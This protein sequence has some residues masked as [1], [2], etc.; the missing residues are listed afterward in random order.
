MVEVVQEARFDTANLVPERFA[1]LGRYEKVM[2]TT[3][4]ADVRDDAPMTAYAMWL[5]GEAD[6]ALAF[7]VV[8][9]Q[10]PEIIRR[11]FDIV[12]LSTLGVGTAIAAAAGR[13]E[14]MR[15]WTE[16][17]NSF[18]EPGVVPT[19]EL[20]AHMATAITA[21]QRGD[22]E[23]AAAALDPERTGI[24]FDGWPPRATLMSVPL[25]YLVRPDAR[26]MFDRHRYGPAAT[27]ALEAARALVALRERVD[28]GPAAHLPWS[29][30]DLLRAN[31]LPVHLAELGAAACAAGSAQAGDVVR[32]LP[33]R[34]EILPLAR[35][36]L[37]ERL[38]SSVDQFADHDV[39]TLP[40]AL[41]TNVLGDVELFRDGVRVD[42]ERWV[43]RAKVR[44]LWCYLVCRGG[45]TRD[46]IVRDLWPDSSEDPVAEEK[47]YANLRS[48]LSMLGK[49]IEPDRTAQG[50]AFIHADT[51]RIDLVAFTSDF[52]QIQD[53]SA[54]ALA[55]DASQAPL[56]SLRRHGHVV[57]LYRGALAESLD[58]G[59]IV[60]ERIRLRTLALSSLCRVAELTLARGEPEAA[61]DLARRAL[62][63]DPLHERAGRTFVSALAASGDRGAALAAAED[64][65]RRWTAEDWTLETATTRAFERLRAGS[66]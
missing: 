25:V 23:A 7:L 2:A 58:A 22:E 42:D 20:F 59:W 16:H 32:S 37:A 44:E 11:G 47:A 28:P 34:G 18:L 26:A 17:A 46:E 35:A 53:A 66:R 33:R 56:E 49:I 4:P 60:L 36:R 13:T 27:V 61:V 40:F 21:A 10:M 54:A 31:V 43:R 52:E 15:R 50:T 51:H 12:T 48:T 57:D 62:R 5:R 65:E 24:G 63:H 45:G 6:P 9:A 55:A 1:D 19:A 38:R 14:S 8:D 39:V 30:P 3:A 64:L 41:H 29:S